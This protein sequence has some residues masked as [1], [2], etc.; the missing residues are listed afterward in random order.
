MSR[1]L[2]PALQKLLAKFQAELPEK[3]AHIRTLH[4]ATDGADEDVLQAYYTAVHRIAGSSGS[5]GFKSVSLTARE[6]D[7][8]L[9]DVIAG[10]ARYDADKAAELLAKIDRAVSE[11]NASQD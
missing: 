1:D 5:Y 11:T 3:L 10:E 6:L 2:S 9:S 4:E 8:Y 7:R